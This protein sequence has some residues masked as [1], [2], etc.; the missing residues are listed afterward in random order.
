MLKNFN[1]IKFLINQTKYFSNIVFVITLYLIF[2]GVKTNIIP[3]NI[4]V[5]CCSIILYHI[6]PNYYN[7]LNNKNS[8]IIP[9]L[10]IYDFLIHYLPLIIILMSN[11]YYYKTNYKLCFLIIFSYLIIFRNHIDD[12]YFKP[13]IYFK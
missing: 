2:S 9:F 8:K 13:H 6:Y 7:L 1:Y 12:I 5:F 3:L 4:F 11:I 10:I